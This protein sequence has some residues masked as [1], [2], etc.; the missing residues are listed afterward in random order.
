MYKTK[1][2]NFITEIQKEDWDELTENNVYM[3]Y[4][5]LKTF[6]ETLIFPLLP[7]YITINDHEKIIGASV[8]YFEQKNEGRIIDK[9]ILGKLLKFGLIEKLSLVPAVICNRQRGD[10]T[11][12]IFY[13]WLS[14]DQITLLQNKMLDEIER[15]ANERKASVCFL[16]IKDNET[17]LMKSLK[18]RGYYKSLDLPSNFIDVEWSSFKE[19]ENQVAKKYFNMK[20]SIRRELNKNLKSGVIIE[21]L[22]NI[23]NHQERLFEL[24]KMNH[25]KY[26]S[27]PFPFKPDYFKK[28][29]EN[30]GDNTTIYS[31]VKDGV[32]IGVQV[33]LRRG[34]EAFLSNVGVDYEYSQKDL[35]FFNLAYYEPIKHAIQFDISRIYY[36]RG[37]YETKIR[38]GCTTQDMFIFYKPHKKLMNPFVNLW[39][40][41]HYIWMKRK[42]AYIKE[43]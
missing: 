32:I 9:V 20:K 14:N 25:F 36:G 19:Y 6:E 4:E 27:S 37:S 42:L 18:E 16:N 39:F 31:A 40:A 7:Y 1:I 26:N 5:F 21:Q 13:P 29:K 22:E 33:E 8:C 12:F 28:I 2:Y 43:L 38:R 30:F 35:T 41:F 10:G 3:C 23:N 34:N 17:Q 15:I 11:H 24:L